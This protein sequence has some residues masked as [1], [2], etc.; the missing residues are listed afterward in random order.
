MADIL[1]VNWRY[2]VSSS[3]SRPT[4]TEANPASAAASYKLRRAGREERA[5]GRRGPKPKCQTAKMSK[6]R[7]K[8]ANA[9]E[10]M[11]M[12]E[13]NVAYD[14]LK[15]TIPLPSVGHGRQ[16]CEKLTKINLLHIAINY[17]RSLESIL[18]SG[19]EG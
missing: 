18:Q 7:R 2:A 8:T 10:R 13:I 6:Y 11:R 9:R 19:E 12:G 4:D 1:Q 5:G 14:R 16:K 15:E 3:P 17:I